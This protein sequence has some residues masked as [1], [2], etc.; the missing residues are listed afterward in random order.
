MERRAGLRLDHKCRGVGQREQQSRLYNG[1]FCRWRE[2]DAGV[3]SV[4]GRWRSGFYV[5]PFYDAM[6]RYYGA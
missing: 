4:I 5:R 2:L 3:G 6:P 1:V